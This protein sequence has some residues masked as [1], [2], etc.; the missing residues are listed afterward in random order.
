[1]HPSVSEASPR[2]GSAA[3]TTAGGQAAAGHHALSRG[4]VLTPCLRALQRRLAKWEIAHLREHAAELAERLEATEKRAAEAEDRANAAEYACDFWHDQAVDAH[5]AAADAT[6]S[7]PG[8]TTDGRLVVVPSPVDR[9]GTP[10][11][12]DATH[13]DAQFL[14][15]DAL[16][17]CDFLQRDDLPERVGPKDIERVRPSFEEMLALGKTE[18]RDVARVG[19]IVES[20]RV[21]KQECRTIFFKDTT[22]RHVV[23]PRAIG[24]CLG[25]QRRPILPGHRLCESIFGHQLVE[26]LVTNVAPI[27]AV[28]CAL[29]NWEQAP[30]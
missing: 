17:R 29:L 24:Q 18:D 19:F 12:L 15:G 21:F 13:Q 20:S 27:V 26:A 28:R 22:V 7:M 9:S 11:E 3:L 6:G 30:T 10:F 16:P 23:P 8:I 14:P 4:P 1:M 2:T 5:H 25:L